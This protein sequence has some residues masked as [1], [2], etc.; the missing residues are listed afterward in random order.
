MRNL[1]DYSIITGTYWVFTLTDGALRML[2]LLFL[3]QQGYGPLQLA[4]LFL[5]YEFF[6]IVTNF[7]GGWLGARF[8]L[9]STLFGGLALQILACGMLTADSAWLT[10][11]Y[12]M[13]AQALS[14]IAKDLTKMSSKSYLKMVVPSDDQQGLLHWVA[15]LTGSKNTLK[16]LGFFLGGFL[17]G[18][19]GFRGAC[20]GMVGALVLALLIATVLLPA[21]VGK[22][23]GRV[24]LMD[25]VSRN[26]QVNFLSAARLFLFAARDVWFVVALPIFLTAS[27]GWSFTQVGS[28]MVCWIVGYGLVQALAPRW[29][30][31]SSKGGR[32]VATWTLTLLLPLAGIV[33]A[34]QFG[35]PPALSLILGLG[36]FAFLFASNSAIHSYLILAYADRDRVAL[37]VGFYYMANAAGRLLGTVLSGLLFQVAGQGQSGLQAC[38]L[39]SSGLVLLS[40][41]LSRPLRVAESLKSDLRKR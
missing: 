39:V 24:R 25:L 22:A 6:G 40:F 33:L 7:I 20:L 14:G 15:L 3:H 13:L 11:P 34:L 38:L 8:G 32:R 41:V 16:G 17:L 4:S 18:Q 2:V 23:S 10:V 37:S 35:A 5:F 30:G 12:V 9:K 27:L 36:V 31:H 29:L 28:F 19:V 21:A 1:R 26:R